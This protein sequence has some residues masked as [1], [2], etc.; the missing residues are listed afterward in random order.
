MSSRASC[1][2]TRSSRR[3][4]SYVDRQ[5]E[6]DYLYARALLSCLP[7]QA[8]ERLDLGSR[9]RAHA[10][11]DRADLRGLGLAGGGR[12]R[13][14]RDLLRPRAEHEPESEHLSQI[15]DVMN[16]RFGLELGEADQLLFDQFEESWAADEKLAARARNND[17]AELPACLRPHV[18][19]HGRARAWTTTRRS[20]SASSTSP[21]SSRRSSTTTPSGCTGGYAPSTI[22]S[23]SQKSALI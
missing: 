9:G 10:P 20:S 15:V 23:G 16:E 19:R 13:G 5:L 8:A 17:F 21:I 7:G 14:R 11:E 3:S 4:S 18:P 6:R 22:S 2:S 12:G 1:A